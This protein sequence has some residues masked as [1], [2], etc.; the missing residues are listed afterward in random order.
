MQ[1]ANRYVAL[2]RSVSQRLAVDNLDVPFVVVLRTLVLGGLP[3]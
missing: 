3:V 2:A 1:H